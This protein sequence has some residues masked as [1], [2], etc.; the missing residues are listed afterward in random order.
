MLKWC[1]FFS[2]TPTKNIELI[3]WSSDN[4]DFIG[5]CF[6]GPICTGK[7][8][9]SDDDAEL[10]DQQKTCSLISNR[11]NCQRS[12]S[13]QTFD[14]MLWAEFEPVQNLS[15]GLVE[16]RTAVGIFLID[17][18]IEELWVISSYVKPSPTALLIICKNSISHLKSLLRCRTF[19][20]PAVWLVEKIYNINLRPRFLPDME[21]KKFP[22]KIQ[23]D[24]F[25]SPSDPNKNKSEISANIRLSFLRF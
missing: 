21:W 3:D 13:S 4:S 10:F 24:L 14:I 12:S 18:D 11:D 7:L 2:M 8:I 25:W 22:K 9:M 17:N 6:Q 19:R 16:R 23:N 20:N 5:H 1:N 15:S